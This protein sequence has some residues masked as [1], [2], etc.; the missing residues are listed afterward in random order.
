MMG[1]IF[2]VIEEAVTRE[3]GAATWDA[4]LDA[5]GLDGSYSALGN[6]PDADLIGLVGAAATALGT[7]EPA[8]LRW[9][10][11]AAIPVLAERFP[12]FFSAHS[13]TLEMVR[14]LNTMIHP[15]V[16][17]LYPGAV[18]PHFGFSVG[19]DGRLRMLYRSPRRLCPLAEGFL[20]GVAAHFQEE[21]AVEEESCMHRADAC[22]TFRLATARRAL[23]C[24]AAAA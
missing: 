23:S 2:N 3:H 5:A 1:V 16:R 19:E 18:C 4:L 20:A 21:L 8:V 7:D 12:H 24:E 11:R 6:Y 13:S 10:G 14:A 15:E 17:K 9:A 22:C